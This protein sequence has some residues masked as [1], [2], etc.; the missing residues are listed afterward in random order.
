MQAGEDRL[1]SIVPPFTFVLDGCQVTVWEVIRLRLVTGDTWYH[2][3]LSLKW[4]GKTSKRFP[5]DVRSW[6]ELRKKL[7]VEIPKFKLAVMLGYEL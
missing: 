4:R 1:E 7:L 5:L 3:L 2:V 6:R